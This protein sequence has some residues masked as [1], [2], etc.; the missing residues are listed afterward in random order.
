MILT[1]LWAQQ[2]KL[3]NGQS[4]NRSSSFSLTEDRYFSKHSFKLIIFINVSELWHFLDFLKI[5]WLF[6]N[7][8]TDFPPLSSISSY[9]AIV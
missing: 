4:F 9:L 1:E 7:F 8:L 3:K 5:L 2:K 6:D